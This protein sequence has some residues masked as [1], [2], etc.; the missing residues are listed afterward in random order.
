M[1]GA[2]FGSLRGIFTEVS[3]RFERFRRV[4]ERFQGITVEFNGSLRESQV[5]FSGKFKGF[6]EFSM[7]FV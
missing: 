5:F 4:S 3:M 2:V 1:L 7:S 6:Q